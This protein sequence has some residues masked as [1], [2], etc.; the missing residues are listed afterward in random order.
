M[1]KEFYPPMLDYV[2]KR[3]FGDQRNTDILAAF[4]MAA[5]GLS[6]EDVD[7]LAIVDPHLKREFND[8]KLSIL[9][10]KIR[11]K[12][13]EKIGVEVQVYVSRELRSR[14]VFSGAKMLTG[15]ISRREGHGQLERAV[16]IV[17]CG[18]TLLSEEPGYYSYSIRNARTGK[19]FT[20]ILEINVLEPGKLP[21]R[22]AVV[23]LG[24]VLQRKDGGGA[25]HGR[26]D[27]PDDKKSRGVGGGAQRGRG[28]ADACP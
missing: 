10:V 27:G 2:F 6:E 4:L 9:D 8:D 20:D 15:Q 1:S 26:E 21:G 18:E 11:L 22:Q 5:L 17:I 12:S 7:R 23:Q 3:I 25:Q 24:A 16:G 19:E 28:G 13:G 14:V